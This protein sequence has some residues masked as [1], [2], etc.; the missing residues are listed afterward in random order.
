MRET[1]YFVR[2]NGVGFD[3][4]YAEIVWRFPAVA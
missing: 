2:D 3:M 4:T 1:I